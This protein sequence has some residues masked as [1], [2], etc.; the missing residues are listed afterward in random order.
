LV[1][2]IAAA[3]GLFHIR[4]TMRTRKYSPGLVT[5]TLLYIPLAVGGIIAL[6]RQGLLATSSIIQAL[7]F[8]VVYS[9]W[10]SWQHRRHSMKAALIAA[11]LAIP[12]SALQAQN[13]SILGTWRGTSTCVDKENHPACNDEIVIYD[14]RAVPNARD[15]V[16]LR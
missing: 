10:S 2:A 9:T 3:N 8:A 1:A 16:T 12:A 5:G 13:A 14:V 7:L 6:R 4:A 11:L 15:T